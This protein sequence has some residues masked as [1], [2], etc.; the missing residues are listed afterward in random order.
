MHSLSLRA[1]KRPF[2]V[3]DSTI[4]SDRIGPGADP[5]EKPCKN[6]S[7]WWPSSSWSRQPLR[8]PNARHPPMPPFFWC[9][10]RLPTSNGRS[11]IGYGTVTSPGTYFVQE[12]IPHSSP[13]NSAPMT[14]D[15]PATIASH[16]TPGASG[17]FWRQSNSPRHSGLAQARASRPDRQNSAGQAPRPMVVFVTRRHRHRQYAKHLWRNALAFWNPAKTSY[18]SHRSVRANPI[19]TREPPAGTV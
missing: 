18:P 3:S 7:G 16:R 6:S 10:R 9:K 17:A 14:T 11:A 2:F 15:R 12:K 1:P 4:I 5:W 8:R 19:A 13:A